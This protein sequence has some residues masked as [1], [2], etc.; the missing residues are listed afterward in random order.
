MISGANVNVCE[1]ASLQ[2][3][4]CLARSLQQEDVLNETKHRQTI[5][6]YV[7]KMQYSEKQSRRLTKRWADMGRVRCI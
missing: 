4:Y 5:S 7:S 1:V 6:H 2:K 3:R